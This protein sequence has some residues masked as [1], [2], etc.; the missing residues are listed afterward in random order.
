MH[1]QMLKVSANM[2]VL[3]F[4]LTFPPTVFLLGSVPV[5]YKIFS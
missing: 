2:E 1:D 3:P 4:L 5:L